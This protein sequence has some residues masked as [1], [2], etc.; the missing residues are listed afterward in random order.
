MHGFTATFVE[1]GIN[2]PEISRGAL[3]PANFDALPF[4][5]Q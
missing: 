5:P 3:M 4:F 1:V 2:L